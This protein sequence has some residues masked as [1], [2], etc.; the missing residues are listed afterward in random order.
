MGPVAR[1]EAG[2]GRAGG[3]RVTAAGEGRRGV[4]GGFGIGVLHRFGTGSSKD[5]YLWYAS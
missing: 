2:K 1:W 4:G 5:I 3:G